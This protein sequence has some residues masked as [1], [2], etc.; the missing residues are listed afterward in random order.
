MEIN[1]ATSATRVGS[2]ELGVCE[3]AQ[4]GRA[5]TH[6]D[7]VGAGSCVFPVHQSGQPQGVAPASAISSK[8]ER[9][10]QA[11]KTPKSPPNNTPKT[12]QTAPKPTQHLTTETHPTNSTPH[13]RFVFQ[14]VGGGE[15][16]KWQTSEG[17]HP[18]R[19]LCHTTRSRTYPVPISAVCHRP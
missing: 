4:G 16:S 18:V 3:L 2:G 11:H 9:P 19:P 14:G 6:A 17:A 7:A 15:C 12:S 5:P 13:G 8:R 1:A 10:L